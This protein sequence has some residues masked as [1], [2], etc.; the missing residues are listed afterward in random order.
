MFN[1]KAEINIKIARTRFIFL[2]LLHVKMITK[3]I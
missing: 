1:K 2:D 3:F